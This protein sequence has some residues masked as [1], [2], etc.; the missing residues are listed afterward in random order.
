MDSVISPQTTVSEQEAL[1]RLP[2]LSDL[3]ESVELI[4]ANVLGL[5]C[6]GGAATA[7]RRL[8]KIETRVD[9]FRK[10]VLEAA[11]GA[12]LELPAL[13]EECDELTAEA[14]GVDF[15]YFAAKKVNKGQPIEAYA[16][17]VRQILRLYQFNSTFVK[18][19]FSSDRDAAEV[20][21]LLGCV[22]DWPEFGASG[23]A[24]QLVAK[25][26]SH[27]LEKFT[28]QS[29]VDDF[30][31]VLLRHSDLIRGGEA[32]D[33]QKLLYK[34][35]FSVV[36][37]LLVRGA[38]EP[39]I[40]EMIEHFRTAGF[41]FTVYIFN[42]LLDLVNKHLRSAGFNDVALALMQRFGVAPNLV[43][44]N[45][46]MDQLCIDGQFAKAYAI[47]A[48]LQTRGV[49]PDNFTFSILIKG[50]KNLRDFNVQ[51]ADN[52]FEMYQQHY[53]CK[54]IIIYN[55]IIDVYISHSLISR[56][57]AIYQHI[58][59][60]T[61]IV[62]DQI[63][64]NTLIKG[65]CK[66]KDF[67]NALS[68][69]NEMKKYLLKPN[70][71]TY[72]S[73]MDLAVKIPD[74][75][76]AL[77]FVE[78]MQADD[79][80]PDGFTY[81]I[82]LN[83]L[84]L[85]NSSK[86]LV[87]AS[88]ENILRVIHS[89][90]I[91]LDEVFFNSILDVCSKYDL[92][93]KLQFFYGLMKT[94][95]INE[96]S[97]TFSI[98]IKAFGKNGDFDAA[99]E[100]YEKMLRCGMTVNEITYGSILDACSKTGQM[101]KAVKIYESL[102]NT[103]MSMNSIVYTTIM[104]GYLKAERFD[105]ALA[106]FESVRAHK[107]LTGMIITYNCALD[108]LVRKGDLSTA[109]RLFRDI[110]SFFR[111]DLI[112]YSTIIKGICAGPRKAEGLDYLKKMLNSDIESDIS[113][114]NL[115]LDSCA[116]NSDYK[117]AISAYQFA[118][119]KNVS[120]NEITF[121]IMIKVYGFA[122]ELQK[123]F[124]LLDLMAVFKINPSIVI[125]T[126]LIHISFYNKC[127]KKAETAFALYKKTGARGD[128]LFYS[129]L[130]DGLLR[131]DDHNKVLKYLDLAIKDECSLKFDTLER[132]KELAANNDALAE[133]LRA[134]E[135]VVRPEKG[136]RLTVNKDRFKNNFTQENTRR[137]KQIIREEQGVIP[138]EDLNSQARH[139]LSQKNGEEPKLLESCDKPVPFEKNE[140]KKPLSMFNFRKR[141]QP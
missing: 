133:K 53:E 92:F 130:I 52:F 46:I 95:K 31:A 80:A 60:M 29:R 36:Q 91:K 33:F 10:R 112:S 68:Y 44:Y 100:L 13:L 1:A 139:G 78:Q 55:S 24:K 45:T 86:E 48:D 122:H 93:D 125:Y 83:G 110:E 85:N 34:A 124:D 69:F 8:A 106:F 127:P 131:F 26:I 22:R 25:V 104:K 49:Q 28:S 99:Y 105:E 23:P 35:L 6:R 19:F 137:Y 76:K 9:L 40:V 50:I 61:D 75:A 67:A 134:L 3:Y 84:K 98:L 17:F 4:G 141:I 15:F 39:E 47:F 37:V 123:A 111:A 136:H 81:S 62:P 57:N 66:V 107:H 128:R 65:C 30:K 97:I 94:K 70:R 87:Q 51:L 38:S 117:I 11:A 71:I 14:L 27:A 82:L 88:L 89:N 63:T 42:K 16:R 20:D 32:V 18:I 109:V 129:K 118:M 72:N 140:A 73:L 79:I 126:N 59:S 101:D 103:K 116:T 58:L 132:L 108:C 138:K 43:T 7:A 41:E 2:A 119:T 115:F 121:G 21:A 74:M 114:V 77:F 96:S 90:E 102:K 5:F 64:F 12:G 120:P 54:D 113:V 56:A 135:Q